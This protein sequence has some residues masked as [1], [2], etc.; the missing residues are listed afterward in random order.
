MQTIFKNKIVVLVI[1][2]ILVVLGYYMMKG[3]DTA[4]NTSG[5]VTKQAVSSTS[6]GGSAS[7]AAGPGQE[8]VAQ[9]LAIQNITLSL[10][11]FSDPVFT[12]LQDFSRDIPLQ[13][14]SRPN[15]F[16]P[17]DLNSFTVNTPTPAKATTKTAPAS[18]N[19][20]KAI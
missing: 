12:G 5:G 14:V 9:L 11:I 15:P 20:F 8:F 2:I 7:L 6:A 3:G 16:A 10:D 17:I 1:V 19:T 4:T 18:T 13:P